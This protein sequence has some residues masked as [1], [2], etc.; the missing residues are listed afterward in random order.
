MY[1][2]V[3]VFW[4]LVSFNFEEFGDRKSFTLKDSDVKEVDRGC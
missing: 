3:K 1:I 2:L 4:F